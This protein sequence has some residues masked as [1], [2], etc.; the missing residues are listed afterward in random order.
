MKDRFSCFRRWSDKGGISK[1][2]ITVLL[3]AALALGLYWAN[4]AGIFNHKSNQ[5]EV[6][7]ILSKALE[8]NSKVPMMIDKSTRLDQVVVAE[9]AIIYKSTLVNLTE[10]TADQEVFKNK[11]SP[12]LAD[13]Y[14][15]DTT[16]RRTLE[17]GVRYGHE[18]FG[19]DGVLLYTANISVEDC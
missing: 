15:R 5:A 17:L 13:K 10:K 8:V 11:I 14:C 6:D 2:I 9:K 19:K 7:R 16:S 18:Y 1:N 3:V 12:F 4:Q